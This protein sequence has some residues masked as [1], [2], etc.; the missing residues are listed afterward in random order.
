M[1]TMTNRGHDLSRVEG[2]QDHIDTILLGNNKGKPKT[3]IICTLGPESR[4]VEVLEELLRA[5][6]SV[7]R[8]NFSHGTHEYHQGTLDSLNKAMC[9][10]RT[11]CAVMLDTKGPEIRTGFLKGGEPVRLTKGQEVTVTSD[12]ERKGD[13]DTIALSYKSL[14][15]DVK[16]GSQILIA[17]GSIVL[18]VLSCDLQASEVRCRCKNTATLGERKNCNLPGV[19]V[20]LPTLTEKDLADILQWGVPND[21][22]FIA[23]SFVRKAEDLDNIRQEIMAATGRPTDIK[24]IS[25]IENQEGLVNFDEILENTDAIM[26]ARGGE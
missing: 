12:Y 20:D 4:S 3:K 25:K 1:T 22:D 24:I 26:V 14:A 7:A 6:M 16:P 18:E 2:V 17:D 19:N 15:R 10:T 11:M 8:F 5:G 13:S 21:I 23:A 9:N